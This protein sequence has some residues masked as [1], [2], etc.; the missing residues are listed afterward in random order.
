MSNISEFLYHATGL[1]GHAH[2]PSLINITAI[3]LVAI[4]ATRLVYKRAKK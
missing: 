4:V 3:A 1:C 2:H